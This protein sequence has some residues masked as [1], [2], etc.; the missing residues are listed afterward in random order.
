MSSNL[1][2]TKFAGITAVLIGLLVA[3][4]S[5]AAP[6]PF[7]DVPTSHWAASAVSALAELRIVIGGTD[8]LYRGDQP[9]TDHDFLLML[10]RTVLLLERDKL[11]SEPAVDPG[12]MRTRDQLIPELTRR[13][14]LDTRHYLANTT[15]RT[16]SP[17]ECGRWM[18]EFLARL[19]ARIASQRP[20]LPEEGAVPRR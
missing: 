11:P 1:T 4:T 5:N 20:P 18:A 17:D 3:R 9:L 8:G 2:H 16:V 6:T 19:S 12:V 14:Y 10:G 13:G 7:S 15:G